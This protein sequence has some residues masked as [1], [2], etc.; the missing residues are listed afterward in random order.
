MQDSD[1]TITLWKLEYPLKYHKDIKLYQMKVHP[2]IPAND[3]R[4]IPSWGLAW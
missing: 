1:S 3:Q 4:I 2:A